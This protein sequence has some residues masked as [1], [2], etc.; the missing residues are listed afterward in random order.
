MG[1]LLG[2]ALGGGVDI[3]CADAGTTVTATATVHFDGWLT[4]IADYDG[5]FTASA[6]KE[7]R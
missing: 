3:T 2:G 6:A 1:D 4:S 5:T 7:N